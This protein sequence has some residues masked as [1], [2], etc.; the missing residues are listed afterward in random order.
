MRLLARLHMS[1]SHGHGRRT[2]FVTARRCVSRRYT[3]VSN[4]ESKLPPECH[5]RGKLTLSLVETP[6]NCSGRVF[7]LIHIYPQRVRVG[8]LACVALSQ[9][10]F[11]RLFPNIAQDIHMSLAWKANADSRCSCSPTRCCWRD[12]QPAASRFP[13]PL[14]GGVRGGVGRWRWDVEVSFC[15]FAESHLA[16]PTLPSPQG[17]GF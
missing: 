10:C 2:P 8:F 6:N 13:S 11:V 12:A 5:P 4:K 3:A 15:I 1:H 16:T 7:H 17:E 14:W 9:H